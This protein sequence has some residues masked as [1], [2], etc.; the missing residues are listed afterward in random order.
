[1]YCWTDG[2]SAQAAAGNTST[3]ATAMTTSLRTRTRIQMDSAIRPFA[4]ATTA[5]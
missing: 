4:E 1:V 2:W 3:A 5:G